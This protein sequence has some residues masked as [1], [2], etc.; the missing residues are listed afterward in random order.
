MIQSIDPERLGN[1]EDTWIFLGRGNKREFVGGL[2]KDLDG[3]MKDQM[4]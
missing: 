1:K 3:T 2:E 4:G